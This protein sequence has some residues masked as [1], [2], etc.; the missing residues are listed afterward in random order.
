MAPLY[1][2]AMQEA[3]LCNMFPIS[4]ITLG[5]TCGPQPVLPPISPFSWGDASH[6]SVSAVIPAAGW[7]F[8]RAPVRG[9]CGFQRHPEV[10]KRGQGEM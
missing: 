3:V 2:G 6:G 1:L 7:V 9:A 10:G 4:T 8:K 5:H